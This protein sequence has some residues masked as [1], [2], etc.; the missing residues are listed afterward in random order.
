MPTQYVQAPVANDRLR[1]LCSLLSISMYYWAGCCIEI[2]IFSIAASL[3]VVRQAE[4]DGTKKRQSAMDRGGGTWRKTCRP[5]L[6]FRTF[7]ADPP[8]RLS[9]PEE[10][11]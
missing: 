6:S 8:L 4:K 11:A 2:D 3:L 10:R 7:R 9:H 1:G 5:A